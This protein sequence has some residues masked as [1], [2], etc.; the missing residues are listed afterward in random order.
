MMSLIKLLKEVLAY[1]VSKT[2]FGDTIHYIIESEDKL[3]SWANTALEHLIKLEI[4][5]DQRYRRVWLDT[6]RKSFINIEKNSW[7]SSQNKNKLQKILINKLADFDKVYNIARVEFN[8]K[9]IKNQTQFPK[10]YTI[11]QRVSIIAKWR[12]CV[13]RFISGDLDFFNSLDNHLE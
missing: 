5:K 4:I 10:E 8:N 6:I 7:I 2:S 1:K 12:L 9:L 3:N 11:E 13:N